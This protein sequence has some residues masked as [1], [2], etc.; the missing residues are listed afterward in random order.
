MAL[1]GGLEGTYFYKGVIIR[2]PGGQ[3]QWPLPHKLSALGWL[4]EWPVKR[5]DMSWRQCTQVLTGP[6]AQLAT[7]EKFQEGTHISILSLLWR[8]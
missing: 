6:L 4:L 1:S 8:V 3:Q 2:D 7:R 5:K